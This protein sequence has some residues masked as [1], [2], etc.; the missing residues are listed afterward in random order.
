MDPIEC[1]SIDVLPLIF[2]H[3]S[4]RDILSLSQVSTLCEE[5]L[6]DSKECMKKIWL[7]F[8]PPLNDVESLLRSKRK[9]QNFKIQRKFPEK[10]VPVF[11]THRWRQVMIRDCNDIDDKIFVDLAKTVEEID[12]WNVTVTSAC[13]IDFPRLK[14]LECNLETA[15]LS[16]FCGKNPAL[17]EVNFTSNTELDVADVDVE[18]FLESNP[19][20]ETLELVSANLNRMFKAECFADLLKLKKLK[21][22]IDF[23]N[24][25]KEIFFKFI[26]CQ[27]SLQEIIVQNCYDMAMLS[28]MMKESLSCKVLRLLQNPFRYSVFHNILPNVIELEL[29]QIIGFKDMLFRCFP[30]LQIL[31]LNSVLSQE[32]LSFIAHNLHSIRILKAKSISLDVQIYYESIKSIYTDINPNIRLQSF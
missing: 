11:N 12:I 18:A 17:K 31:C 21:V 27:T 14:K 13:P 10:C 28:D 9:Y 1:L 3:L 4:V 20:I 30:N 25:D 19:Q 5:V 22:S 16:M 26:R 8:Y 23:K 15:S 24:N 7:R 32:T 29:P 2:Q 6:G